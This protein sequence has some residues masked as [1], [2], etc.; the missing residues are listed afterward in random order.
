MKIR[1]QKTQLASHGRR[2]SPAERTLILEDAKEMGVAEAAE[3]HR[4]SKWTIYDWRKQ[5]KRR[6]ARA[7]AESEAPPEAGIG[8]VSELGT[9]AVREPRSNESAVR[10][11]ERHQLILELWRQQPG[12]GPS[13]IRNQVKRK[14]FKAS[15][16]T[17]RAI[18]EEHGYV[19]PR[20]RRKEH[21]GE[22]EAVRPLQLYHLDFV[23]FYVHRQKQCMLLMV[24]DYSRFIPGW[25]LLKSEHADGVIE[26][27]EIAVERYG[28]PEAVMTD[29]GS[30]FHSWRGLSRFEALLEEY[31]VDHYLA[32]EAQVNGKAEALAATFQKEL[33]RQVEMDDLVDARSQVTR[34]VE[35]YNY[36]RTHH[37][38]GGLLVPADRFHG[39]EKE[40]LK[41]IEQGHGADLDDLLSPEGRG[42]ELFK[43]VSVAG[44]PAVYL[45]GRRVLG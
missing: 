20:T 13:Q 6:A 17:V 44:Q 36:K 16:N 45:M 9:G 27:F 29:R 32:K 40:T 8:A 25:T 28:K 39:F 34:W 1:R 38:L 22:Y 4:C 30:A 5:D 31:G 21:T 41:R 10:Q 18:M 43:V 33:T 11:E 24:D 37:G 7:E 3:K 14:G 23:H 42:L 12:L 35:F 19:Q 2:Y 15:V 26:A